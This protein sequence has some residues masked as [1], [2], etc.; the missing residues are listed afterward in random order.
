MPPEP[1]VNIRALIVGATATGARRT[2]LTD[3]DGRL[4]ISGVTFSGTANFDTTLL[5]KEAKQDTE[6]VRLGILTEASPADDTASSGLNGRLQRIAQRLTSLIALFPLSL[7]QKVRAESFAVTLATQDVTAL[8]PPAAIAGYATETKQNTIIAG[9]SSIDAGIPVGLGQAVMASSM[10]VTLA[11]DQPT[12]P[13]STASRQKKH[14]E[15]IPSSAAPTTIYTGFAPVGTLDNAA[16]WSI[17]RIIFTGTT[18]IDETWS[19]AGSVWND[20]ATTVTYS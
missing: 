3:E 17:Q 5:A 12:I 14:I 19:P 9:L 15:F 8:T 11:S 2:L 16:A 20:R 6:L 4:F 10:P 13:V 7:G 18:A 1:R